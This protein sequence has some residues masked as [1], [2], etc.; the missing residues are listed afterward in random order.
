MR[1]SGGRPMCRGTQ[2]ASASQCRGRAMRGKGK[3]ASQR[4]T[5][6]QRANAVHIELFL[7]SHIV[8]LVC[9]YTQRLLEHTQNHEEGRDY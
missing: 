7:R 5:E 6:R 4:T 1:A 2:P 3:Q 9:I 8:E